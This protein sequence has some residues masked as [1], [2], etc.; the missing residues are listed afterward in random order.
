M[1]M[2]KEMNGIFLQCKST[3]NTARF[4]S[5]SL[6]QIA[7]LCNELPKLLPKFVFKMSAFCS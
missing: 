6:N 2:I 3:L 1:K 5:Y 4:N 7:V